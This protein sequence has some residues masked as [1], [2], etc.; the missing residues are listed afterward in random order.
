MVRKLLKAAIYVKVIVVTTLVTMQEPMADEVMDEFVTS[1]IMEEETLAEDTEPF[2]EETN[3]ELNMIATNEEENLNDMIDDTD[4][5]ECDGEDGNSIQQFK[6]VC[7]DGWELDETGYHYVL[8]ENRM[9]NCIMWIDDGYYGFD[10][11]G[12]MYSEEWIYTSSGV[13]YYATASGKLAVGDVMINGTCYHFDSNGIMK[14]GMI[15]T[16]NGYTLYDLDGYQQGTINKEGWNLLNGNY[17]YIKDGEMLTDT[18]FQTSDGARYTFDSQGIMRKNEQFEGRWY[19]EGGWC[20]VGW[21]FKAGSWYYADPVTAQ[22]CTGFQVIN[23]VQYYF[24]ESD[25]TMLIGDKIVDGKLIIADENGSVTITTILAEG[26]S[27]YG[28]EYYYYVDGEPYSGWV[29]EYF[30]DNGCM[31]REK[32]IGVDGEKHFFVDGYGVR[33]KNR[34]VNGGSSYAKED[35]TLAENE[36]LEI[37]GKNIILKELIRIQVWFIRKAEQLIYLMQMEYI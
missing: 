22:I 6:P 15:K 25:Y 7:S 31:Q 12:I 9:K 5:L 17:Y 10:E 29:G 36:W 23:G 4:F 33:Q 28:G 2:E 3:E 8:D 16:E 26:W 14:T 1:E 20:I 24:D 11:Y 30:V 18:D 34:W 37:D 21:I 27:C 32:V 13:W 19:S 35:G